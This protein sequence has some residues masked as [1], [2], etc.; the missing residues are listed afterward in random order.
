MSGVTESHLEQLCLDWF[1][2]GSYDYAYCPDMAHDGDAPEQ[3][4]YQ[5][6]V[7]FNQPHKIAEVASC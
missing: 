5:Q 2:A 3:S 7:Q 4:D 1:R 6:V